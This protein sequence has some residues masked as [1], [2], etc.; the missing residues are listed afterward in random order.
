MKKT[1]LIRIGSNSEKKYIEKLSELFSGIIVRANYFESSKGM[2]SAFFLKLMKKNRL[3]IVD[4]I[5]Y[6]FSI[7][8]DADASI[9]SWQKVKMSKADEKLRIGLNLGDNGEIKMSWKRDIKNP[10]E[11]QKGKIEVYGIIKA[12]RRLA[13]I[14]FPKHIADVVGI[15]ALSYSHFTGSDIKTFVNNV[16]TYQKSLIATMY[17]G[18]KYDGF[19]VP[20]QKVMICPYF[21]IVNNAWLDFMINIWSEFNEIATI[22]DG[23]VVQLTAESLRLFGDKIIE[24][25]SGLKSGKVFLWIENFKEDLASSADLITYSNFV[26]KLEAAGKSVINAYAGGFSMFLLGFGLTGVINGPGY[27]MDKN[28]EPVKGGLPTAK[29]YIPKLHTR[30]MIT[31]AYDLFNRKKIGLTKQDYLNNICSCP[32]CR[33]IITNGIADL[34]TQFGELGSAILCE[35]GISRQYPTSKALEKCAYHFLLSKYIYEFKW[36]QS[37][38]KEQILEKL[39]EEISVWGGDVAHLNVWKDVLK[40]L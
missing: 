17:K 37:R 32:I 11:G 23:V 6:A 19:D 5:T 9:R 40:K 1:Y 7:D 31:D 35:D 28:K 26:V 25:L 15:D 4:P 33:D 10:T 38:D 12:Y 2:L 16:Y 20:A 13:D 27:G 39:N 14:Y 36:I 18:D 29:Y 30:E 34:Y 21:S 8:P 24:K 22:D 3:F